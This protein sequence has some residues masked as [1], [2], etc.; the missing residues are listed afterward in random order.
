M[1]LVDRRG[2]LLP[3][4]RDSLTPISLEQWGMVGGHV[5][6]GEDFEAAAYR[7]R[8]TRPVS[9]GPRASTCGSTGRSSEAKGEVAQFAVWFATTVL[10]DDDIVL[11]EGRQIVFVDPRPTP[12]LAPSESAK[13]FVLGFLD[14]SHYA[15]LVD[16][17]PLTVNRGG[18]RRVVR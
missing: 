13:S 6:P 12:P 14:S 4:E 15:E 10:S 9:P 18:H 16:R 7:E 17:E 5:E 2:L 11:G 1:I 8:P 3:Q